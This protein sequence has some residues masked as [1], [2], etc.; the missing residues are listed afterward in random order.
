MSTVP[1]GKLMSGPTDISNES[2][3]TYSFEQFDR[4]AKRNN[5]ITPFFTRI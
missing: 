5:R 3:P 1:K 4:T 2:I